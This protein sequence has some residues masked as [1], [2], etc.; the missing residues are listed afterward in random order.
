MSQSLVK[1]LD[2]KLES[3][4]WE[5]RQGRELESVISQEPSVMEHGSK[6]SEQIPRPAKWFHEGGIYSWLAGCISPH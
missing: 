3:E 2:Q 1:T 5:A 4:N 6:Y